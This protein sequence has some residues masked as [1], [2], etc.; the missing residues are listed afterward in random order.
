V[1][2]V[3]R[4]LA[5]PVA[6]NLDALGVLWDT[7]KKRGAHGYT[8]NYTRHLGGR[9]RAVSC[10]LEIGIGGHEDP[11]AGG[12][13]LRMWRS[14]FPNATV[15]GIDIYEKRVGGDSRI[16][17]LQADQS[18]RESLERAVAGCLPFDLVVDDGSHVGSH[19][20]ISFEVLFPRVAPGGLYVIEDVA[21]AYLPEFGGGPPGAPDTAAALTK[22]LVDD[23]NV[24][25]RPIAAVHAYPGLVVVEK[26]C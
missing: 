16:V 22:S 11:D 23:L 8:T 25:P 5:R 12:G 1:N 18:D 3:K 14:Y 6:W 10:V 2:G 7:D 19:I 9:R 13:S 21:T 4:V 20:I 24:G 15:Y 26:A 17:V